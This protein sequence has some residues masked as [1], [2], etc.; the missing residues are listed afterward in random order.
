MDGFTQVSGPVRNL[1]ATTPKPEKRNHRET[2]YFIERNHPKPFC[3]TI[4][5]NRETIPL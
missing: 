3:E 2:A 4:E 5:R 1:C